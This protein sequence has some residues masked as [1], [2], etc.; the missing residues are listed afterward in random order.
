MVQIGSCVLLVRVQQLD[1]ASLPTS[2][3]RI[4]AL[5]KRAAAT[6][7]LQCYANIEHANE[8]AVEQGGKARV[9]RLG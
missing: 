5:T 9:E 2:I 1:W 3:I 4:T 8:N 6:F 7:S